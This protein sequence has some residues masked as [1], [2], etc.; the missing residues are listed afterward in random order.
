MGHVV[1]SSVVALETIKMNVV[2]EWPLPT[3]VK[4][5]RASLDLLRYHTIFIKGYASIASLLTYILQKDKCKWTPWSISTL[6]RLEEALF[7]ALML[8]PPDFSLP[9]IVY[10]NTSRSGV[11]VVFCNIITSFLISVRNCTAF[12]EGLDLCVYIICFSK[13]NKKVETI[14]P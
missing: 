13:S 7:S 1:S 5:L 3:I 14:S 6:N 9:F 8:V 10:T 4:Q 12:T 11:N 2:K